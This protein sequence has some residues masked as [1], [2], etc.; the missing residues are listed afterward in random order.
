MQELDSRDFLVLMCSAAVHRCRISVGRQRP[1]NIVAHVTGEAFNE[2]AILEMNCQ[3][4]GI[5]DM[6]GLCR[7]K[8][9]L[10]VSVE[11]SDATGTER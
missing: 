1:S 11:I 4:A 6:I 8:D 5:G 3:G 7:D 10:L 9:V 2:G